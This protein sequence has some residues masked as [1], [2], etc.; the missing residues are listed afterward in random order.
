M[1]THKE[2][3]NQY[4]TKPLPKPLINLTGTWEYQSYENMEELLIDLGVGWVKRK[5]AA[6]VVSV[7]SCTFTVIQ[8]GNWI[9]QTIETPIGGRTREYVVGNGK[10]YKYKGKDDTDMESQYEWINGGT[11]F[12]GKSKNIQL[13]VAYSYTL[14]IENDYKTNKQRLVL[15]TSGYSK[16]GVQMK[17]YFT[18]KK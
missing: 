4:G 2:M 3:S 6:S 8:H 10:T 9:Q 1:L 16:N 18:K 14:H 17:V 13:K 7:I 11:V 5:L 15:T 12:F